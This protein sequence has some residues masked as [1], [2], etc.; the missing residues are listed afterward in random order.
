[1]GKKAESHKSTDGGKTWTELSNGLPDGVTGKIGLAISP[2]NPD[3]VYAAIELIRRSGGVFLTKNQGA[4]WEKMSDAVSGATGPHY[5]QELYASPHDFGTIYLVRRSNA[6]FLVIMERTFNQLSTDATHSDSH[7]LNF[8]ED[9][10]DFLLLGM[11]V[12]IYETLD[13]TKTWRYIENLVH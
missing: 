7:S 2:Q 1:V 9:E 6:N 3:Y 12:E 5:Y 11:T 8:I 10:P 13:G 4:S